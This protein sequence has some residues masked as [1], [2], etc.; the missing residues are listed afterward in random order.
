MRRSRA[1]IVVALA[2]LSACDSGSG[3][4]LSALKSESMSTW[5]PAG[6]ASVARSTEDSSEKSGLMG[7]PR[8]AELS[9]LIAIGADDGRPAFE[10]ALRSAQ[11]N[12]WE[13][14]RGPE[15]GAAT[16]ARLTK[17]TPGCPC[18]LGLSLLTEPSTLGDVRPPAVFVVLS[19]DD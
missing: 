4:E 8:R 7:K 9:R 17:S 6:P 1:A 13:L 3:P 19:Y 5:M 11:E 16:T 14:E 12:G 15:E 10:E 2:A 18:T